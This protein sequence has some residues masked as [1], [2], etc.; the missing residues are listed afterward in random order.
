[1]TRPL[2]LAGGLTPENV[3]EAVRRVHPYGVDVASGIE[4]A[5][6][7]KDYAKMRAFVSEVSLADEP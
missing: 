2:L 7:L 4:S 1:M 5:P 3:R 6:G